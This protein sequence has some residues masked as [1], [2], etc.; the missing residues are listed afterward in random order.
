MDRHFPPNRT[1]PEIV[2]IKA[3]LDLRTPSGLIAIEH[4]TRKLLEIPAVRLVQSAS[5][6]AGSILPE[7]QITTQIGQ[8]RTG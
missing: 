5:R 1:L 8:I 7:S 3:D 6:P 4:V 2:S